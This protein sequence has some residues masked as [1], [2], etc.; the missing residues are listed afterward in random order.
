MDRESQASLIAS[1]IILEQQHE[2]VI[3]KQMELI[4]TAFETL[5]V[6]SPGQAL[7]VLEQ[8]GEQI[9]E[10]T[11]ELMEKERQKYYEE[12]ILKVTP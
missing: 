3:R 7:N 9:D 4:G 1:G 8:L 11:V 6:L 12:L 2:E 5:V 10:A